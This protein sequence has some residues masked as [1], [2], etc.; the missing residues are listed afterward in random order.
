MSLEAV[1]KFIG[2][3]EI[4]SLDHDEDN[5]IVHITFVG[6]RKWLLSR[7]AFELVVTD[8]VSDFNTVQD[9]KLD[10]IVPQIMQ[11][12]V[13][14]SVDSLE[15]GMLMKRLAGKIDEVLNKARSILWYRGNT[16]YVEGFDSEN[17]V[18]LTMADQV[19][20]NGK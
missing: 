17:Y 15:Q 12:L 1:G 16:E 11:L 18:S 20:K 14:Y 5:D 9:K 6:G 10:V 3:L 4:E 19:I 2:Q 8:T 13:D 7:K